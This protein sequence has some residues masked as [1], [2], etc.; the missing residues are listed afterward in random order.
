MAGERPE[1][2][3]VTV[4]RA[5]AAVGRCGW[6]GR[7]SPADLCVEVEQRSGR[8]LRDLVV[9]SDR[10]VDHA[11][12][13]RPDAAGDGRGASSSDPR[14]QADAREHH[15][16]DG[17]SARRS[18][19]G[20]PHRVRCQQRGTVPR[21]CDLPR[22]HREDARRGRPDLR[23]GGQGVPLGLIG[24]PACSRSCR[25]WAS[26]CWRAI[27]G[28]QIFEAIGISSK[29][30]SSNVSRERPRRS[31]VIG[32]RE[33]AEESL[34]ACAGLRDSVG[35]LERKRRTRPCCKTP[36]TTAFGRRARRT[37]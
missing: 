25:R 4:G 32:F 3:L 12:R 6:L 37:R 11:Q 1:T 5:V 13:A 17:R 33:I 36:A 15:L 2:K 18:S 26:P 20:V 30:R 7:R 28:A 8:R 19:D 23:A 9:L 35:A 24:E 21:L 34:A 22:D 16:R 29:A 10:G 31:K 14:G 27:A